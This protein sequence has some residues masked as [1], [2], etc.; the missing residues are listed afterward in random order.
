MPSKCKK[1]KTK[2]R[3]RC[4]KKCLPGQRR[5]KRGSRVCKPRKGKKKKASKKSEQWNRQGVIKNLDQS[6]FYYIKGKSIYKIGSKRAKVTKLKIDKKM[7]GRKH[8]YGYY[9]KP[10]EDG[11]GHLI[12]RFKLNV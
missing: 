2:V 4:V 8:M 12:K 3:R 1:G 11:P 6:G 10:N 5:P 7:K 9:L